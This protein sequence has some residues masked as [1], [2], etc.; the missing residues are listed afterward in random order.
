M[1]HL[2]PYASGR[3]QPITLGFH[4]P[5][6]TARII[7]LDAEQVVKPVRGPLGTEI[8]VGEIDDYA[9]VLLEL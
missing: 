5:Y 9:A 4:E 2:V 6:R 3:T 7:K 8:P 1:V